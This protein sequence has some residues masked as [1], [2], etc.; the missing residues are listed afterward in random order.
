VLQAA[1]QDAREQIDQVPVVARLDVDDAGLLQSVPRVAQQVVD[2]ADRDRHVSR[3]ATNSSALSRLSNQYSRTS[4]AISRRM[5]ASYHAPSRAAS[6][7]AGQKKLWPISKP[8][9]RFLSSAMRVFSAVMRPTIRSI[10]SSSTRPAR[11]VRNSGAPNA[12]RSS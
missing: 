9:P 1:R 7:S 5:I 12:G 6:P 3:S 8:L 10:R 11:N 2:V 4:G